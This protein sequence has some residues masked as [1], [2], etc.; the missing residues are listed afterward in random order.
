V[1]QTNILKQI[2]SLILILNK[3]KQMYKSDLFD[4]SAQT[5]GKV[6]QFEKCLHYRKIPL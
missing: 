6:G 5:A 4:V 2:T 3:K 1:H